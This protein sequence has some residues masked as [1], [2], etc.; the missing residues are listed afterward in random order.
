MV[1]LKA[2]SCHITQH[3]A[4]RLGLITSPRRECTPDAHIEEN[5]YVSVIYTNGGAGDRSSVTER[6]SSSNETVQFLESS[7]ASMCAGVRRS[8]RIKKYRTKT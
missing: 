2:G 6:S 8:G 4:C 7:N 5:L 3:I 1:T